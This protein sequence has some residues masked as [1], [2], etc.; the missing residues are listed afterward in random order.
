MPGSCGSCL[1]FTACLYL[2]PQRNDPTSCFSHT[3]LLPRYAS[4]TP[5]SSTP[6]V[7]HTELPL[8]LRTTLSD[9]RSTG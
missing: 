7:S 6:P 1:I 3:T 5:I 8:R 9:S 4:S 2:L